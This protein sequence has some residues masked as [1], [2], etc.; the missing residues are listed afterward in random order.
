ML[1]KSWIKI[2][3]QIM[4]HISVIYVKLFPS[5]ENSEKQN[6]KNC[7]QYLTALNFELNFVSFSF[8]CSI[9]Q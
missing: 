4:I 7:C 2:L 1:F 3:W 6:F 5:S 8:L 9:E